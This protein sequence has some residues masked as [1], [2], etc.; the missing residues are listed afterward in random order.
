MGNPTPSYRHKPIPITDS[1]SAYS[2]ACFLPKLTDILLVLL[3]SKLWHLEQPFHDDDDEEEEEEEEEGD[4]LT[5][6]W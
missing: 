5:L 3:A 4:A 1:Y 2:H 6:Q